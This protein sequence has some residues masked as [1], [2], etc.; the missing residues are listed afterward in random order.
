M[1][2]PSICSSRLG[3]IV[4]RSRRPPSSSSS[5]LLGGGQCRCITAATSYT[6]HHN[7]Q[8]NRERASIRRHRPYDHIHAFTQIRSILPFGEQFD[9][10]RPWQDPDFM[11]DDEP[12]RVEAWLISLLKSVSN[13][14]SAEYSPNNP[15]VSFGST[16]LLDST[17]YLRVLEAYARASHISGAPQKAEYWLN[18]SIRHYEHARELFESKY[19]TKFSDVIQSNQKEQ[20]AA[21]AIVHGL[22]PDVEHYNAVIECWANSKDKISVVRSRT[23]LSKLEDD[24]STTLQPNARSYD[25][26]LHS[27]SRGIGKDAIIHLERA[28]EAERILQ[29]RLS[30]D[31]PTSIRPF[32]GS[33][34]YVLRAY[35]RCRSERSVA[36][37]VMTLVREMEAIQKEAVLNRDSN[38]DNWKMNVTP[39]TKTYTIAMDA[40]IIKAGIKSAA[41]RS[42]KLA[43]NNL[44]KQKG[45]QSETDNASTKDADGTK[46][47]EFA[48]SILEYIS[49]LQHVGQADVRA[50]VVGYNTLLSGY[51][52]LSNELRTDMPQKAEQLLNEMID[53]EDAN[54]Y[55]DVTSFNAVIKAWGRAKKLNSAA[56]SEYWLRKMI[57]ENRRRA[58][59]C[60]GQQ[61]APDAS[62]YNLVMDAYL[63]Q[64][65]PDAARVQDLLLEMKQSDIVSPNSES[66]SKVIRAWLKD[67][68]LNQSSGVQGSSVERAWA[69]LNEL[70]SLEAQG[71]VGPAPELYTSILKT[72]ARS[73]GRGE[74]LLAVA[75]ESFWAKRKSRFNIDQ[76]DYVFL[77]EVGMKVL[78]GKERDEF[79]LDLFRQCKKDGF[80]SKRL[81]REAVRGP[82]HEEWP[83]EETQQIVQLLFGEEL[84]FPT[85]WSRNVHK[86]DRPT[87]KDLVHV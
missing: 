1:M 75:Q 80:V 64:V 9:E 5:N 44:L 85:S 24:S 72:A 25:L 63:M 38:V 6:N 65:D 86:H 43:R 77:L 20:S 45:L 67:E 76:I 81:V 51:A 16:F 22:R 4:F 74:N 31:A 52:R 21:A 26:Y 30:P 54:T 2:T 11:N 18:H 27:V 59:G 12:D 83:E 48:K 84:N 78:A 79:M 68:L 62:T 29:Y 17:I 71:S 61:I 10:R 39:N 46:E 33:F 57:N 73:E 7:H 37:K 36:G 69:N 50:T 28:Q 56:R 53:C 14:I 34:N 55:P 32:T 8:I 70:I 15:P 19:R 35:T 47:L 49:A 58:S 82:L 23:W 87:A 13:D 66:Y 40:W 41:W 3:A 42:D 60:D